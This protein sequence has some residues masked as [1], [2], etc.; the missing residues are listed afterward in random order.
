MTANYTRPKTVRFEPETW[1]LINAAARKRG[2]TTSKYIRNIVESHV[3]V[4]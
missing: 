4:S 1:L 3:E 2:E